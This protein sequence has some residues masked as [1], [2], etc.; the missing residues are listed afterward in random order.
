MLQPY[1]SLGLL[2]GFVTVNFSG[3][4]LLAPRPTPSLED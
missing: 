4:V 1:V 3:M 2:R